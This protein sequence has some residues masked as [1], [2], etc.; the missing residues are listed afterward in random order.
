MAELARLRLVTI[1]D[2][3]GEGLGPRFQLEV[4]D[5]GEWKSVPT[6]AMSDGYSIK[7]CTARKRQAVAIVA[8][9]LL[10][11]ESV[12]L[13][14]KISAKALAD[15]VFDLIDEIHRP[16]ERIKQMSNDSSAF[17]EAIDIEKCANQIGDLITQA[18]TRLNG[19]VDG[20]SP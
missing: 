17:P 1:D 7:L 16:L 19:G 18:R 3:E 6:T 4:R 20:N 9:S 15:L 11:F 2:L 14:P 13:D 12:D 10:E 8:I 5:G